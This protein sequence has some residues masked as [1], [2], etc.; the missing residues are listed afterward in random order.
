MADRS[1]RE[2]EGRVGAE[3]VRSL[4]EQHFLKGRARIA[5]DPVQGASASDRSV[6]GRGTEGS[7]P[8]PSTGESKANVASCLTAPHLRKSIGDRH[9]RHLARW[10]AI[11][12]P[13]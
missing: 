6:S 9:R 2:G 3:G 1:R 4:A 5:A 11:P 8:S 13:H 7:N 10:R 12:F